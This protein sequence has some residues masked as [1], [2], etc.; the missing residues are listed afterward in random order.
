[1]MAV[2]FTAAIVYICVG[3]W[4]RPMSG[5]RRVFGTSFLENQT[6]ESEHICA[7]FPLPE[8]SVRTKT[9]ISSKTTSGVVTSEYITNLHCLDADLF[10]KDYLRQTDWQLKR[11]KQSLFFSLMPD[12]STEFERDGFSVSVDCREMKD[13]RGNRYFSISCGW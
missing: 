5:E 2:V 9:D 11:T 10:F 7:S 12:T 4:Y 8:G 3:I 1:M 13:F 6:V